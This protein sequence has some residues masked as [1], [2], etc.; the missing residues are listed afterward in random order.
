M[1]NLTDAVEAAESVLLQQEQSHYLHTA[2]AWGDQ[3][4]PHPTYND[5]NGIVWP[6]WEDIQQPWEDPSTWDENVSA[7]E[8][9]VLEDNPPWLWS[10]AEEIPPPYTKVERLQEYHYAPS[11]WASVLAPPGYR[12]RLLPVWIQT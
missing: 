5:A 12:K 4:I 3:E 1:S 2:P 11:D 7:T 9:E 10:L 8:P 6:N